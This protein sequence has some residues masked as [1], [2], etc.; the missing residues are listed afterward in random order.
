MT[1]QDKI[2]E[3]MRLL[4]R[5]QQLLDE[6]YADHSAEASKMDNNH[7]EDPLDM[8]DSDNPHIGSDFNKFLDALSGVRVDDNVST[9]CRTCF[10]ERV[11]FEF[12]VCMECGDKRCD[13]AHDFN[14]PCGR[15][16]EKKDV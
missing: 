7:S 2:N 3:I 11:P 9:C 6:A 15:E 5:A 14:A 16:M 1:T 4:D 10:P 12:I 8:V 13:G